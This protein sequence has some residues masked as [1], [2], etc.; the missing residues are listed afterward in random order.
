MFAIF[1]SCVFLHTV[2]S[3]DFGESQYSF[4]EDD[5]EQYVQ[6]NSSGVIGGPYQ[7]YSI[8][9]IAMLSFSVSLS[10]YSANCKL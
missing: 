8:S 10:A 1:N 5:G 9:E 4:L 2:I 6:Y 7:N 3:I